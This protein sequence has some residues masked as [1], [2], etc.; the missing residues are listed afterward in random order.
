MTRPLEARKLAG[1]RDRAIDVAIE[2]GDEIRRIYQGEYH[3]REKADRTPVTT[4]DLASN[5]I[6][7]ERLGAGADPFPVLAEESDR[8]PFA[9]RA[10]WDHYWLVDPLDGTREFIKGNGEF[11]VN[12]AL[13]SGHDAVVGVVHSPVAGTTWHAVRGLG[14]WKRQGGGD[15]VP[16]ATRPTPAGRPVVAG[17]RSHATGKLGVFLGALGPHELI[18]MGSAIKSCLVAEGTA[19]I[20]PR[21]GPTSEWDTAAAQCIVEQAGGRL[22]NLHFDSLRYNTRES[23]T[24]PSF[25]VVG[26]PGFDWRPA[27]EAVR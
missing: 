10:G 25:V 8:S 4:A 13:V 3:V 18:P 24:N 6:I 23:L 15:D 27:L 9:V 1:L 11:C 20:Y 14:A 22:T 7:V 5:R 16:I 2:A 12:I 17:S 19:D 26:D 21:F